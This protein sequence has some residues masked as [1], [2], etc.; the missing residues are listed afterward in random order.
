[1]RNMALSNVWR[2]ARLCASVLAASLLVAVALLTPATAG[3][4]Q[5]SYVALGD[6]Y[7]AGPL[8]P[9]QIGPPFGCFRSDHN[10]PHVVADDLQLTLTD[11][12]CSGARTDHMTQPQDVGDGTNPPQFD[13]LSADTQIVT[14]TISGNDIGFT[15]V[16][17]NCI[18]STPHGTPCQDHYVHDGVDELANRIAA[19]APKVDAVLQGIHDRAPQAAVYL[20][21]YLDILPLTG[22]GCWPQMPITVEDLPYLR[23]VE[24]QL[25]QM[26]ADEAGA[27]GATLVD[28]FTPS[29]G[30]DACQLP[31]DRWVEPVIPIGAYPVHP[32]IVGMAGT[33]AAVESAIQ[34]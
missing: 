2:R 34:G 31:T 12:S 1:M 4:D 24:N 32:N 7:T 20:V 29:I 21:N 26:L 6:S 15:E 11:V 28:A 9:T 23:G 18:S 27:N 25:N 33:A 17:N 13:A 3:A 8:I 14:L 10:Y 22:D 16:I 5:P 30:H 19:T